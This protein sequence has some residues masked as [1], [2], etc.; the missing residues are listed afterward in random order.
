[1]I[2]HLPLQG[3]R[4]YSW[5]IQA[6]LIPL[7]L[8]FLSCGMLSGNTK[9]FFQLVYFLVTSKA[10]KILPCFTLHMVSLCLQ[11]GFY[12]IF[13]IMISHH[14]LLY[15]HYN[16]VGALRTNKLGFTSEYL[17]RAKHSTSKLLVVLYKGFLRMFHSGGYFS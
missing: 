1:M 9:Y 2:A 17:G 3:D 11:L 7:S 15:I 5:L 16:Q 12:F 13:C 14:L 10:P 6:F 8:A 4:I